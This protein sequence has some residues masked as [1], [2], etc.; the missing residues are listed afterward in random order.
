MRST[1]ILLFLICCLCLPLSAQVAPEA[2]KLVPGQPVEREIAGGESHINQVSLAAGQFVRF[3]LEQRAID[4]ELILTAPDGKQLAEMDLTYAGEQEMLSLE[5]V[6]PGAYRLMVRSEASAARHG[7][8]RLEATVQ[9]SASALDRKR[10]AAEALV[11]EAMV[12]HK[13][14]P[15]TAPQATEKLEQALPMW[16]E[17]QEP[18]WI[19]VSLGSIGGVYASAGQSEEALK[20]YE[21]ALATSREFK[22][23]AREVVVLKAL[24]QNRYR[25]TQY[26]K[27]IEYAEKALAIQRDLKDRAGEGD[28]L[29]SLGVAYNTMRRNDK[30]IEN[31]EQAL[32]IKRELKDRSGE[33]G[34]RTDVGWAYMAASR[35]QEALASFENALAIFREMKD[36]S[37]ESGA[38]SGLGMTNMSLSRFERAIEFYEQSLAIN[39][40]LKDRASEGV[41]LTNLGGAYASLR[42]YDKYLEYAEQSLAIN[43]ETKSR[44][45]EGRTLSDMGAVYLIL[46][47]YDKSLEVLEQALAINRETRDRLVEGFTLLYLGAISVKLGRPEKA[48]EYYEQSLA[49]N[50]ESKSRPHEATTLNNLAELYRSQRQYEKAIAYSEQALAIAREV[51][52]PEYELNALSNLARTESDRG[53]LAQARARVEEM[54]SVAESLRADV[55]SSTSRASLLASVQGSYQLLTDILMRQHKAEPAKGFDAL[56]VEVSERQRARSLL[57]LLVEAGADLRQGVDPALI[58]REQTLAKQLNAKARQR[59]NTPEAAAALKLEIGQLETEYERAQVAIRKAS[60]QYAALVQPKPLKLNEIQQQLDADTLLLEYA[61]GKDRSYLWAITRDSLTS[62]EL[63][64]AEVVDQSAR[65][66]YELLTARSTNKRGESASQRQERIAQAEAAL[67]AAARGLSQTILAT[68]AAQLGNK[69]LVIVADGALQYIPFAMLPEPRSS[70]FGLGPSSNP[71]AQATTKLKSQRP[72]TEDQP[73]I[74]NHE[75]ISLP[76]A[77]ALAIQR[78]ELAGRKPAPKLLAVIADP[79]FDRSDSR[80]TTPA[81][82]IGDKTLTQTISGDNARS[83]EHFAENSG[84]KSGVTT[85]RLVV[86]RLPFTRQEATRLIALT[87][88]N[89]SFG[90]TDFQASRATALDPAFEPV[91]LSTLCHAWLP[92]Q[93]TSG[94]VGAAVLDGGRPGQTTE[95][96]PARQRYLQPQAA[97]RTCRFERVPDRTRQR[98]QRRRIGRTDAWFYVR[99]RGAC[100]RQSVECERQSHC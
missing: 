42:R 74:V 9:A 17:L 98:D 93:R 44:L 50:R 81:T 6:A 91:S 76:S 79:V 16:R 47:R 88:K 59:T 40:E 37:R 27:A 35:S 18:S 60:P 89:S 38:L 10:L 85:L 2:Q 57:D 86:P 28:T 1:F 21:Q 39:R 62:Y 87:P 69:R 23:Q 58:E 29:N 100:R 83:I 3:R 36:R 24:G 33:A 70:A 54:L 77:S 84:D 12:L 15:K 13:Q 8:Y 48:I 95:W 26:E 52:N 20:Y 96:L 72:K 53:N 7:S 63:P 32:A 55:I 73:L 82:E 45:A 30:A 71:E 78:A 51:K 4:L 65:Q 75:V 11:L 22:L 90:A 56:A 19:A 31:Y 94:P 49:I 97:C 61:L 99:R 66:V 14:G 92:G 80:F 5:A 68:V 41:T 67:P 46:A 25:L 64:K 43:R 34:T